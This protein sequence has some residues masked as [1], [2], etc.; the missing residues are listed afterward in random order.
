M[1]FVYEVIYFYDQLRKSIM[2]REAVKQAHI[3]SQWEGLRNQVNPHFLF[4]SMNTLMSIIDEDSILAKKFLKR[5]SK[6]YRYIL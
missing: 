3:Q 6:V 2:E 4:N 1:I 5:L